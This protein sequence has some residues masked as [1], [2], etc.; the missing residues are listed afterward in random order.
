ME[1]ND[2]DDEYENDF[3]LKHFSKYL[4]HWQWFVLAMCGLLATFLYL[5]YTIP[6]Y[7]VTTTILKDEKKGMLVGT[8]SLC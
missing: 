1:N 2:F 5:R 8:F 6:Q 4:I 3:D 7:N